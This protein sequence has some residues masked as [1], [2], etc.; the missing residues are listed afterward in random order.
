[1]LNDDT[2]LP[3]A[4]RAMLRDARDFRQALGTTVTVPSTSIFG[5]GLKTHMKLAVK[6]HDDGVW[7]DLKFDLAA[8]GDDTIPDW[9]AVLD[10]S[11]VHPVKQRHGALYVDNDVKMRL[12]VELSRHLA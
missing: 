2:W 7:L 1:M 6:R 4:Q 8:R 3:M 12:K 11:D 9:S 10:Q 5:Y